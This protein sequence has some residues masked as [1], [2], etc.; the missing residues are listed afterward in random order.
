L[1]G[2]K[3][4]DRADQRVALSMSTIAFAVCFAAWTIFAIVGLRLRQELGLDETPFGLLVGAPILT[5]SLIRIPLAVWADQYGGRL[6]LTVN[7]LAAAL[8]TFLLSYAHTYPQALAAALGVGV[9]GGSFAGGI[10]YV[11]RWYSPAKQG[12]ALGVFGVGNLGAAA[13]SFLAPFVLVAYGWQMV[14][15]VWAAA[16]VAMALV[17]WLTAKDDPV[18]VER[19]RAGA[20]PRSAWLELEPLKS[21]QV[22]RFSLYYFSVFGAFVAL[23]LWLPQYFVAVYGVDIRLAGVQECLSK[24]ILFGERSLRRALSEYV[25][26]YHAERNHQGK[27]NVLLFGRVTETQREEPVQCARGWVGS[28]VI[29]IKKLRELAGKSRLM[30]VR[31]RPGRA[32]A[33]AD[34]LLMTMTAGEL[35]SW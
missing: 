33:K 27:S 14:A 18:I 13:T 3:E 23:S 9:A 17:F 10:A 11:S 2:P 7:M 31:L 6:V 21:V 22:W 35:T 32:Y 30:A 29:T 19:R 1:P 34:A 16:L 26:H 15:Q 8:A 24:L 20:K 28:C 4:V 5:G 25:A 12:A